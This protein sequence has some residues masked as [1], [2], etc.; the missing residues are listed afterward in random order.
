VSHSPP[1]TI[2]EIP[3]AQDL[4]IGCGVHA[5][6]PCKPDPVNPEETIMWTIQQQNMGSE[7]LRFDTHL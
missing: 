7:N 5:I 3:Q 4:E 6:G 2:L 1:L